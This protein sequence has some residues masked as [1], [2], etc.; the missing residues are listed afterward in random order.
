M[1][2]VWDPSEDAVVLALMAGR[3]DMDTAASLLPRRGQRAI[4]LRVFKARHG[5]GL[6]VRDSIA[7][8]VVACWVKPKGMTQAQVAWADSVG[9]DATRNEKMEAD[10]ILGWAK[11]GPVLL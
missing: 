7:P 9:A 11:E 3:I 5:A 10:M 1:S 6:P 8:H 4:E 2:F